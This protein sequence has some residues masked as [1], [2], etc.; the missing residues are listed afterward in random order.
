MVNEQ[1]PLPLEIDVHAVQA[2]RTAGDDVLLVDCREED[3]FELARLEGAMLVPMSQLRQRLEALQP[4]RDRHLVIHCHHGF[5]SLQVTEALRSLGFA[6]SQSMTGGLD[7][8]S[9]E[10]DPRVPRY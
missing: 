8:W 4:H 9:R 10:I 5:R 2:L 7:A 3:E 6:R 1:D